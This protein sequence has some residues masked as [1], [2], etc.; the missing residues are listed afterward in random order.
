M[1]ALEITNVSLTL[2]DTPVLDDISRH[3]A[4]G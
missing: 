1:S 4:K 3:V 2:G